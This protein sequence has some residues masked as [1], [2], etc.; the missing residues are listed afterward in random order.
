MAAQNIIPNLIDKYKEA[1]SI[2]KELWFASQK[3]N[4][5]TD[6]V[7]IYASCI[8]DAEYAKERLDDFLNGKIPEIAELEEPF[9]PYR[10]AAPI[11]DYRT[12]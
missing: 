8:A 4:G 2:R 6:T 3:P 10:K 5:F 12:I 9:M 11:V 1:Y 7:S